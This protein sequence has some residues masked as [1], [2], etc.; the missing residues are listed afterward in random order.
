MAMSRTEKFVKNTLATGLLQIITM[1][2]GF[3]IPKIMLVFFGSEVNGIVTS[4]TQFISYLTLLEAGLSGATIFSLYKPI[5]AHDTYTVNR[6]LVAAKN[7]YYKTGHVFS[8]TVVLC[9]AIY[10]FFIHTT[11]LDYGELVCLFCIL[12]VNGVLEFYTL[13][14]YRALLTADQKTYVISLASIVQVVINIAIVVILSFEG[15]SIVVVRGVA[16][17]AIFVRTY[18]L[19][20]YC[21]NHYKFLDFSVLPNNDAMRQRWDALYLQILGAIHQGA[22]ILI[23]T[24]FLTLLDVSIYAIYNLVIIGLNSLLGIFMTG[25]TAG[26]G[27]L[28]ARKE[29]KAF[30]K[31]FREF[32]FLYNLTITIIY[33]TMLFVYLPFIGVYT[34]GSD[35]SYI[36][37][38]FAFL[39]IVNGYAY[40]IKNPFGMLVISAGKYKETRIPTTIQGTIELVGG[41][42]LS[43]IWGLNG[44]ILGSILSNLYRDIEFLFFSPKHLTHTS[45]VH[46]I[47][48][49][50]V[51]TVIF[52]L[53]AILA[54]NFQCV[55]IRNFCEWVVYSAIICT[56]CTFI[57]LMVNVILFRELAKEALERFKQI[58]I[59]RC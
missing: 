10:P 54:F 36:Y 18:I 59:R 38:V 6:I 25:L 31:A 8:C 16:V 15:C 9:A 42:M 7:L 56:I 12:G 27:D 1:I 19:W 49:W 50:L 24:F 20:I 37:P 5:A 34:K 55:E 57:I 2:S 30:Q 23:A 35:I 53:A 52:V 39:M 22:P 58:L 46:T 17:L 4:V 14:K 26:F 28:I 29:Q 40:N 44:L 13:A 43:L 48:L 11:K 3:I 51:N 45:A 21:R 33:T 47:R 41:I 32:E